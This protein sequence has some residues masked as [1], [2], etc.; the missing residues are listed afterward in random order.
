MHWPERSQFVWLLGLNGHH[1]IAV[2]AVQSQFYAE[3]ILAQAGLSPA[4]VYFNTIGLPQMAAALQGHAVD[5]AWMVEP[6]IGATETGGIG[7]LTGTGYEAMPGGISWLV[8]SSPRA[9]T[10]TD[11]VAVHFMRAYVRGLRDFY[12]AFWL[13]DQD[14]GPLLDA[15]AAHGSVHDRNVLETVGMHTVDPNA[16]IDIGSLDRY[17]DYYIATDNQAQK[18]D[19]AEHVD[20]QPLEVALQALGRL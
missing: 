2:S 13:K 9:T 4:D 19:L 5:A 6:L 7:Q 1:K 10:R 12:H 14:T 17:Q 3:Q 11:E 15:L 16:A 20:R 18:I 8:L